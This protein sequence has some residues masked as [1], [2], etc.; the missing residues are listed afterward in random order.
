MAPLPAGNVTFLAAN[1]LVAPVT[2]S[3]DGSPYAIL[4]S[5]R[6]TQ[7]TLPW[8]TRL[9]WTS[10]KPADMQ[11]QLIPDEIGE[12]HVDVSAISGALEFT[13]IIGNQ[14]YFTARIFNFTNRRVSIGVWDGGK[15][16]CASVLPEASATNPGF[17]VIGYYRLLPVTELRAYMETTTCSG[18]FV[19]WPSSQLTSYEAKSGLLTLSLDPS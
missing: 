17:T 11:G 8:N 12:Q 7:L 10:A 4:S 2:I 13:N 5:G 3:I 18:S 1:D 9:T 14:T 15:V 19:S 16:W 6:T